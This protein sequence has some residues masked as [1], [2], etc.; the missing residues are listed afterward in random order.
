M[1]AMDSAPKKAVDWIAAETKANPKADRPA[2]IDQACMQ[3]HLSPLQAE[4][5][6]RLLAAPPA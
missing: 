4:H 5:L 2:L 6:Y 3:F 1:G